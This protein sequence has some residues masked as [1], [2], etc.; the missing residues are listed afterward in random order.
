[1][2]KGDALIA[3]DN[4]PKG[5]LEACEIAADLIGVVVITVVIVMGAVPVVLV[6]TGIVAADMV[7]AVCTAL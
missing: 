2:C 3:C 4:E 1:M 6:T 7:G 5:V